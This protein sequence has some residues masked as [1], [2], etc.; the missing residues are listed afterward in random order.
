MSDALDV[1]PKVTDTFDPVL[2]NQRELDKIIDLDLGKPSIVL[3]RDLEDLSDN[4]RETILPLVDRVFDLAQLE[5]HT[6]TS[7]AGVDSIK[8][9]AKMYREYLKQFQ[10]NKEASGQGFHPSMHTFDSRNRPRFGGPGS[11]N[12]RVRT[13]LDKDGKRVPF[14]VQLTEQGGPAQWQFGGLATVDGA[15]GD[16]STVQADRTIELITSQTETMVNLE[17]P[18]CGWTTSYERDSQA[19]E[20]KGRHE[21]AKHCLA[22]PSELEMHQILHTEEF[23]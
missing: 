17:C 18:I 23:T 8:D 21:M 2:Y 10:A 20:D 7:W 6:G 1:F 12:G 5:Q 22:P 9:S 19:S 4:E 3:K 15:W 16:L 13:Y 11:D 14:A